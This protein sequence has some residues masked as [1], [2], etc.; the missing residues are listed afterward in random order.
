MVEPEAEDGLV[1]LFFWIVKPFIH[2]SAKIPTT[3]FATVELHVIALE[4]NTRPP[5]FQILSP[6]VTWLVMVLL[7]Y[8][9]PVA[10]WPTPLLNPL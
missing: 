6:A 3:V 4:F 10:N 1:I 9:M 7:L 8:T 5:Q 2:W